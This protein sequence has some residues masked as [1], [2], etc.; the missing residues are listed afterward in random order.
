MEAGLVDVVILSW[1]D[2]PLLDAAVASAKASGP[3]VRAITVVDNGSEPPV[4]PIAGVNVI[5]NGA[6]VGVSAG[7]NQGARA[8]DSPLLCFLDSD[9][10]LHRDTLD[11]L[12]E[13]LLADERIGLTAPVFTGQAPEE[14]AG[15][16][17]DLGRKVARV[18]GRTSTYAPMPREGPSWEVEFAIGACQ[19]IRRAAFD[20]IGGL[21]ESYFY[22]PE[23]VDFCV[24]LRRAG[25]R[26]VQV[27]VPCDHPPRRRHRKLLTRAG[28]RHAG[29][30]ARHLWRQ[31]RYR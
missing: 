29:A 1:N 31:R 14:S 28:V 17:P 30:V 7:R 27:D 11:R 25:W 3:L 8:G 10:V 2:G 6:N 16:A 18:M 4:P 15:R 19:L 5:R 23:D 22:G 24:R 26:V 13:V 21:D 9:A 12:V 20:G